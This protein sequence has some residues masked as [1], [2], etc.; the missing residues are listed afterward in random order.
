MPRPR[1]CRHVCRLPQNAGFVPLAPSDDDKPVILSVDEYETIR[2]IDYEAFSQE[3][4]A[5]Y[6]RIA[7]ATVQQIYAQARKKLALAIVEG[8]P[9]DISG[10]DYYLC[11]GKEDRC[12]CGGCAA[13]RFKLHLREGESK[14]K[15][16]IP[17]D[18]NKT[19]VCQVLARAPYFL[20]WA[21]G[22]ELI[23]EN[24][25]AAAEGGAGVKVAQFLVDSDIGA[26]ITPRCGENAAEIFK[27]ADINLYES[28]N[29]AA[30]D[31]IAAYEA[32]TLGRL[33][34]FHGGYH[35][36]Q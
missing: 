34:H 25:A 22:T 1:K 29:K 6:M 2:L 10:G 33:T 3:E 15:L 18:E 8:R 4:C 7:R 24:P 26:L 32:G 36:I 21:N 12:D 16:A 23:V 28:A 35:G 13:H 30:A 17:L 14:M 20:F 5:G 27:L 31:D 11:E 19:D 9:L